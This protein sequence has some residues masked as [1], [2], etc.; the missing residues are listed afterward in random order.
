MCVPVAVVAALS[1]AQAAYQGY[2]QMQQASQQRKALGTARAAQ[3]EEIAAQASTRAG[4]RVQQARA[5]R[6]KLTVAAGEAGIS[7]TSV[8][9]LLTTSGLQQAQDVALIQKNA[10]FQDRASQADY[11]YG[12]SRSAGPSAL[13]LGLGIGGAGLSGYESGKALQAR[14]LAPPNTPPIVH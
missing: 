4:A 8:H 2:S 1:I 10:A 11:E 13:E 3:A 14:R 7:G 6:A 9:D 5:E 12:L